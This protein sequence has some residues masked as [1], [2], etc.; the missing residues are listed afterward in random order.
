M[1][2]YVRTN[3]NRIYKVVKENDYIFEV[4]TLNSYCDNAYDIFIDKK[5]VIKQSETIEELCDKFV[6][7]SKECVAGFFFEPSEFATCDKKILKENI[8]Y[9]AIWVKGKGLIYVAKMNEKGE[10]ELI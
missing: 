9:G 8:V 5:V 3:D 6:F 7:W 10:L 2:K 1:S 4:D